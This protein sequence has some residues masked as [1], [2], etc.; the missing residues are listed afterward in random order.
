MIEDVCA[1][2]KI[3]PDGEDVPVFRADVEQAV[4]DDAGRVELASRA[5]IGAPAHLA[6]GVDADQSAV[7]GADV[8]VALFVADGRRPS[9][10]LTHV[11]R[12]PVLFSGGTYAVQK[13]VA[14]VYP[15]GPVGGDHDRSRDVTSHDVLPD[16]FGCSLLRHLEGDQST[17]AA[18]IGNSLGVDGRSV[19]HR[20]GVDVVGR[21]LW[22][23][24]N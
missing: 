23:G 11:C 22:I 3:Q 7:V 8:G 13:P 15:N 21:F 2:G 17:L 5:E 1:F 6:L 20:L 18:E 12:S 10:R 9:Q 4:G 16:H 24:P 19:L 14:G